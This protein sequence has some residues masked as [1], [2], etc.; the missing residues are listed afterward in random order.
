MNSLLHN[1]AKI[2]HKSRGIRIIYLAVK[3]D[4]IK[5]KI[6][7]IGPRDKMKAYKRAEERL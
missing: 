3:E 5:I 4:P 1:Y 7:A 6:I 2:K